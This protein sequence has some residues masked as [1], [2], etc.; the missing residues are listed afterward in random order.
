MTN[1]KEKQEP[2]AESQAAT[3]ERCSS[4]P[5]G[6]PWLRCQKKSGHKPPHRGVFAGYINEWTDKE[7]E[8]GY[9]PKWAEGQ[10]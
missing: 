10:E 8:R 7:S 4:T 2:V 3:T 5:F 6:S 1:N 9:V